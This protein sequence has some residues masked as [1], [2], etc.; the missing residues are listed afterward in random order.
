[1]PVELAVRVPAVVTTID[2]SE[3]GAYVDPVPTSKVGD[4]VPVLIDLRRLPTTKPLVRETLPPLATIRTFEPV[5]TAPSGQ[6]QGA[7]DRLVDGRGGEA[8]RRRSC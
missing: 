4:W 8:R 1:M 2:A 3:I 7:A 5:V 6:G